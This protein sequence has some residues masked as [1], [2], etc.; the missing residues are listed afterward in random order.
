MYSI[1]QSIALHFHSSPSTSPFHLILF[2]SLPPEA[3]K[4]RHTTNRLL[5][6]MCLTQFNE[7][8]WIFAINHSLKRITN[9]LSNSSKTYI[10]LELPSFRSFLNG[11]CEGW[12]FWGFE[13]GCALWVC[14]LTLFLTTI[15]PCRISLYQI[16][17]HFLNGL[18]I[19]I[20]IWMIYSFCVDK[21]TF[22]YYTENKI[23]RV[24]KI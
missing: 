10:K 18:F 14:Y 4:V 20:S 2:I 17:Y 9:P 16:I 13:G 12:I 19:A 21:W 23:T 22:I 7:I 15:Y 24:L 8:R 11:N 1:Y 6:M 3:K 5:K